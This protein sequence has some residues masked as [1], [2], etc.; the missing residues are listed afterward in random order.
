MKR[1]AFALIESRGGK[2]RG[3]CGFTLIELLV[4]IAIIA[5]LASMMMPALSKAR[6]KARAARALGFRSTQ[7]ADTRLVC[8]YPCDEGTFRQEGSSA[9]LVNMAV[10][11]PMD[12]RYSS[13]EYDGDVKPGSTWVEDGGRWGKP[14]MEFD[15]LSGHVDCGNKRGVRFEYDQPFSL[16][17]WV[18]TTMVSAGVLISKARRDASP[19]MWR[20]YGIRMSNTGTLRGMFVCHNWGAAN[21]QID[22]IGDDV[23]NDGEWH[24]VVSTYDGSGSVNGLKLYVDGTED[25]AS[26]YGTNITDTIDTSA[27]LKIGSYTGELYFDG[28]IDEVAVYNDELTEGDVIG[29]YD[30][31]VP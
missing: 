4:V 16:E 31:G 10:G 21:G 26:T 3:T 18:R 13:A 11:D 15:G 1:S 14:T 30:M 23:I 9:A 24:H 7:R 5:V 12:D 22:V 19:Q 28:H 27:S 6:D 17:C 2:K 25:R 8:Y 20:G 29:H